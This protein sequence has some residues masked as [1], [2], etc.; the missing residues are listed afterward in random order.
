MLPVGNSREETQFITENP[1]VDEAV[2]M[3]RRG[4]FM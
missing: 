2:L 3:Y 1:Q 4:V